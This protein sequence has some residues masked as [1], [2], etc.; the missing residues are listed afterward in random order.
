MKVRNFSL[1]LFPQTFSDWVFDAYTYQTKEILDTLELFVQMS[2]RRR[3]G[4]LE[5]T[6]LE[7]PVPPNDL[8]LVRHRI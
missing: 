4:V 2:V 8:V 1:C 6:Q 7:K 3:S 5:P